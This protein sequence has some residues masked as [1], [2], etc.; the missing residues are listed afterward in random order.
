MAYFSF[1]NFAE[2]G[3]YLLIGASAVIFGVFAL[4]VLRLFLTGRR[5]FPHQVSLVRLPKEKPDDEKKESSAQRLKE[6]IAK[7]ETLFAAIGGLKAQRGFRAWLMGR[8]D[9]FSLEIVASHNRIAFYVVA[10]RRDSRYLEQQIHA[11]YP[12]AVIEE[13]EDYNAFSLK[14]QIA[15]AYLKTTKSF[16]FP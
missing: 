7:G 16:I 13:V 2:L 10:P 12:E 8:D 9:Q 6:E 1:L 4:S 15:A 5:Y 3:L 11:H 14:G